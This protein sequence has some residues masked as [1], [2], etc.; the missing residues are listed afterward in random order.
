MTVAFSTRKC[1]DGEEPDA[2]SDS[3]TTGRRGTLSTACEHPCPSLNEESSLPEAKLARLAST[4]EGLSPFKALLLPSPVTALARQG[5]LAA[6]TFGGT[7]TPTWS[8]GDSAALYN[9]G[10]QGGQGG[11][12]CGY[13]E[14]GPAGTLLVKPLGGEVDG[15]GGCCHPLPS[16]GRSSSTV[17]L[18]PACFLQV[19]F[20][21]TVTLPLILAWPFTYLLRLPPRGRALHRSARP[22]A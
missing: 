15:G 17:P 21:S 16:A 12:G 3:L 10:G 9:V 22:C 18:A 5:S 11:W 14:V 4:A 7:D 6:Y 13:F 19:H 8:P 20:P 2:S 1:D